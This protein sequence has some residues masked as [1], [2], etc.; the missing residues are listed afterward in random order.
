MKVIDCTTYFEED[1]IMDIR[2]NILNR[3]VDKFIVCE[4]SYSHSGNEKKIN[5]DINKFKK[6]KEKI[7]HL[8]VEKEPEGII[9]TQNNE[10]DVLRIN[11]IKR[12]AH[13]RNQIMKGLDDASQDDIIM[14]SDNDEIPNLENTN[15]KSLKEKI[16]IFKQKIF[17]YKFNLLY[18]NL[19]WYGTKCC[20]YKYLKNISQ[21]RHT[22]P[23]KYDFYRIDTLFSDSKFI[24]LKIIQDGGWHF[25]NLKTP[26]DLMKKYLND[27]MH[28]EFIRHK[29]NLDEIKR[30]VKERKI[31]YDHFAK[32]NTP[33]KY[34]NEFQLNKVDLDFLPLFLKENYSTYKE[35]FD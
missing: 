8:I 3:Y 2:F 6:F 21:L 19:D 13:Q 33:N 32:T 22:K 14:Y 9:S 35:W 24:D 28:S 17:Y 7:V 27:E 25:T 5:F 30:L 15:L 23:K 18:K 10:T 20:K 4:A 34:I 12:I 31:N 26:E 29:T 16:K 1:L 11:S